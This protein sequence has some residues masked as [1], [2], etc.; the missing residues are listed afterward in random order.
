MRRYQSTLFYARN[1]R[2]TSQALLAAT[3]QRSTMG[4]RAWTTLEHKDA[5]VQK[6][7]ALWTNST[8]GMV[9]HWTQGQRTH[10][11]RSTT[12]IGALKQI[13]CPRLD[14]LKDAALNQAAADFDLLA[15]TD[16]LPACQA[17]RDQ[18]RVAIDESVIRMLELP[19]QAIA[20][21]ATLR[22]LWCNEPSVQWREP[23]STSAVRA[24]QPCPGLIV[25]N[26]NLLDLLSQ[27]SMNV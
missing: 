11:G 10:T 26:L 1:M 9:V 17:H 2:W 6:A 21:I 24:Q 5:R 22:W 7:F 12:Q 27:E 14:R 18:A 13:P 25:Q 20:T 8:F 3:T 23:E 16:L 4:G 15:E 19:S